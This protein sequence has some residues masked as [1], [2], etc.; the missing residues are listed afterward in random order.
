[1]TYL[2]D[3]DWIIDTLA[4]YEPAVSALRRLRGSLI[5][6]SWVSVAEVYDGAYSSSNPHLRLVNVRQ[7]VSRYR[8]L[9]IDDAIAERFAQ[10]RST[11][12][13]RG[14]LI[15]D[16]DLFVAVTALVY[17]LTLLT[18]NRRHFERVPDL[19]LYQPV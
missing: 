16:L 8:V 15:S 12:R 5:G 19:K 17:D 2:L 4:G 3:S 9:G 18:F 11:L 10:E 13:R 7:F 6:I 14:E 1:M